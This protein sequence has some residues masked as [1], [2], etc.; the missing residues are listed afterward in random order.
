MPS[1]EDY[2]LR[3]GGKLFEERAPL[4]SLWQN[5]AENFY[6]IRADFTVTR[7]VGQ[8]LMNDL[9]TGFPVL[10]HRQLT[11]AI[12]GMLRPS[13]KPWFH[14]RVHPWDKANSEDR[15]WLEMA[16]DRQR[17]AMYH[18]STGFS[19][20]V[21][22]GDADF[23]AFGQCVIQES[24]NT[25]ADQM[26]YRCWHL[27]DVVWRENA[28][29]QINTIFRRWKASAEDLMTLFPRTVHQQVREKFRDSPYEEFMVWHCI[30]PKTTYTM[31]N[32][33]KPVREYVSIFLDVTNKHIMEEVEMDDHGYII[34]RWQTIAGS[35][36]AYSP[37]VVVALPDA[38]TL[39]EMTFTLLEAGEKAVT[40]PLLGVQGALRSDVNV[41]AG[42]LTWVD[43][44][45]D[46]RL[47][48]VLRPLTVDK[49]GIPM[50]R[51]MAED[52]KVQLMEAFFLNKLNLPPAGGPDM[53][54]YEVGQRVQEFIRNALPLF[55]PMEVEYN[56]PLTEKTFT[57]LMRVGVFGSPFEIP[58][59]L[60]GRDIEFVFESP[61]RD[62][63]ER[64]K[65][66]KFLEGTSLIANAAAADPSAAHIID[67]RKATRDALHGTG[68]PAA[69]LRS[70]AEVDE[71]VKRDQEAQQT[72]ELLAQMQA[73]A[74]IAKTIGVTPAPS[75]TGNTGAPLV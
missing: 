51:D 12:G 31:S 66:Q 59:G 5:I 63:L 74:D 3:T 15:A 44:E 52:I 46:E 75:G 49:S 17:R 42:G 36:Y 6:P 28:D 2:L 8:E 19:R 64:E 70:E 55:E 47:G 35:Q 72:A 30:M 69:W 1:A 32:G 10:L 11:D 29:G 26:L 34:P 13:N 62:A 20:A 50:G 38:R 37:A 71:L 57:R 39:Q 73:G 54:A 61:L 48:E 4:E 16:E 53:T 7:N 56:A 27:R 67:V 22:Q 24:L 25:T 18:K 60:Q 58:K 40:P 14:P 9:A 33:G 68:T 45:Y 23:A 65:A 41:M 21:K 43:R